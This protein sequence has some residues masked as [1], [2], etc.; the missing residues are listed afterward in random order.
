MAFFPLFLGPESTPVT[1][2]ILMGHVTAIRFLYQTF[3][4]VAGNAAACRLSRW[5]TARVAAARQA[6]LALI[7]F[8]AK[9]ALSNR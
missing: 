6:G 2:F 4:V 8:G 3:L 9:L 5:K 7:C 1:L